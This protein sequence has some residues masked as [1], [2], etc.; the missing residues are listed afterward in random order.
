MLHVLS[1]KQHPVDPAGFMEYPELQ[2]PHVFAE[3]HLA[4]FKDEEQAT[5]PT[6]FVL[7]IVWPDDMQL[8]QTL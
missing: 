4:Q 1:A 7:L 3:S 6:P 8:E 5:H 2:L